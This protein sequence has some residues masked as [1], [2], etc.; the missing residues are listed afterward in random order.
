MLK[1]T[2]IR[3][4][5]NIIN[6]G[7]IIKVY[8]PNNQ[9]LKTINKFI[10]YYTKTYKIP[11]IY[12]SM[13]PQQVDNNK[14][15]YANF[16]HQLYENTKPPS[17]DL[18]NL[19]Y[20]FTYLCGF[21]RDDKLH[22]LSSLCSNDLLRNALWSCG[23]IQKNNK[24]LILPNLPKIIDYD[25][26]IKGKK[27]CWLEIREDF[28]KFSPFSL[29]QETE[30]RDNNSR[31]TEKT[32]KCFWMKHPFI[33][34]GNH[35]VLDTLKQDGFKTFHPYI[36][37][38]YDEIKNRDHRILEITKQVK[39]LCEKTPSD[40]EKFYSDIGPIL[41]HNYK[42]AEFLLKNTPI[43]RNDKSYT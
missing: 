11:S 27:S 9:T 28:Y 43:K 7:N 30:M 33:V 13:N 38:S 15:F 40:W 41:K 26:S 16:C 17:Y 10:D 6:D 2:E 14:V 31:Y 37:E 29:V 8:S 36:D 3:K 39:K 12:F 25:K 5:H 32:Y 23:S 24:K 42:N 34:A 22:M 35:K 4:D 1:K 21:P 20:D 18:Y 19:K